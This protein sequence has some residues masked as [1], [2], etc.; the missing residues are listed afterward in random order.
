VHRRDRRT[1]Q[2]GLQRNPAHRNNDL[3]PDDAQL[4]IEPGAA[5]G[6]LGAERRAVAS[7]AGPM[8]GCDFTTFMMNTPSELVRALTGLIVIPLA[9]PELTLVWRRLAR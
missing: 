3:G 8:N 5:G 7:R 9:V 1:G 6:D 4:L 2:E